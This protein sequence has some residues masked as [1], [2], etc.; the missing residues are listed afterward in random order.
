MT[1]DTNKTSEDEAGTRPKCDLCWRLYLHFVCVCNDINP[2]SSLRLTLPS[3]SLSSFNPAIEVA[4]PA[5]SNQPDPFAHF[6]Q[7]AV[8]HNVSS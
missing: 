4:S 2:S 3:Y 7:A 1:P 6:L 8:E 5:Q